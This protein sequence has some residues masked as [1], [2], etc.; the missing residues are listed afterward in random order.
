MNIYSEAFTSSF[1]S[2]WHN[3]LTSAPTFILALIVFSVGLILAT[4]FGT[5]ARKIIRATKLDTAIEKAA[6][7]VH[8]QTFGFKLN[9]AWL[10]G[11]VV[12][13][14]FAIVTFI[15]VANVLGLTQVTDFLSRVALYLPNVLVAILI[16]GLGLVLARFVGTLVEQAVKSSR[17]PASAGALAMMAEWAIILFAVMAALTQLGIASHLIEILFSGLVGGL[18]LAFGLSFGLGGRDSAREWLEKMTKGMSK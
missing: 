17:M 8:L 5:I 7:F 12:E 3:V 9:V 13:W 10:V 4:T 14:F 6:A 1:V 15:A 11:M 16:L 18:A 2:L